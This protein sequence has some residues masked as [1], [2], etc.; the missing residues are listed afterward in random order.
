MSG[1]QPHVEAAELV[2]R[3]RE[4]R[5]LRPRTA[6][7]AVTAWVPGVSTSM[8]S[9]MRSADPDPAMSSA[10]AGADYATA[11]S[12]SSA[13]EASRRFRGTTRTVYPK[14]P[15]RASETEPA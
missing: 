15:E 1:E 4:R 13:G 10:R 7:A 11:I 8:I 12:P 3:Q 9:W 5:Q 14:L 6:S 2:K